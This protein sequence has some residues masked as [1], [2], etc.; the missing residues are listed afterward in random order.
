M[1]QPAPG[2]AYR[3]P[4]VLIDD[5]PLHAVKDFCYLGSILSNDASLNKEILNR[6]SK[7]SAS[8]G[9]LQNR[10]WKQ[11]GI[12]RK[13]KIKVYKACVLSNLLYGCE[14]WTVYRRHIRQLETFHHRH[15]RSILGIKWQ[16]KVSNVEVLEQAE[17]SSIE[18]L[19][20][21][22]QLRWTGHI[23]RMGDNR[24]PKQL[25]YGE[26]KQGKRV[27]GGQKKPFKDNIKQ[28]LKKASIDISNWE[29]M[30]TDR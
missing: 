7:A 26:L 25:L 11:H 30:A 19:L 5:R 8:F 2:T 18:E 6:I 24:I 4:V 29:K 12:S 21:R 14:T 1:Y 9:S 13:T 22:S 27:Q 15:L 28:S 3:E 10:V 23:V 16:D 17:C 20:L